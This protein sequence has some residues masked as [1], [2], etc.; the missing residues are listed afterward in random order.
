M[1]AITSANVTRI[2]GNEVGDRYGNFVEKTA[3]YDVVLS[4]Q[5]G[6]AGDIPASAFGFATFN[7]VTC[8]R[9]I[10]GSSNLCTVMPIV[11]VAGTGFLVA[12]PNTS[13][14]ANRSKPA[15]FTGTV[16]VRF[17]GRPAV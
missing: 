4:S 7:W 16:R 9:A 14:D 10:D 2:S 15:N 3:V 1:A 12:D 11:E 5:G 6:T 8:V 17:G 13:T